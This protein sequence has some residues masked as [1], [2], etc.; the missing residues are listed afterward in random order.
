MSTLTQAPDRAERHASTKTRQGA[1]GAN[2][3]RNIENPIPILFVWI[4]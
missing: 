3:G 1:W 2:D 4:Q